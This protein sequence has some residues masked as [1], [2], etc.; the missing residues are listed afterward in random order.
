MGRGLKIWVLLNLGEAGVVRSSVTVTWLFMC[1]PQAQVFFLHDLPVLLL[2]DYP[3]V[4][5]TQPLRV[6]GLCV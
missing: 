1:S 3:G 2:L 6:Q 5:A 4:Q